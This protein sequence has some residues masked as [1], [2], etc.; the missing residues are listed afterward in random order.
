MASPSFDDLYIIAKAELQLRRPDLF[1]AAGDVSDFILA[2][3]AAAAD[4]CIQHTNEEMRKTFLD[5][6]T[7]D[8]LTVLVSDHFGITRQAATAAQVT[9]GFTRSVF[10]AGAGS[11]AIGTKVATEIDISGERQEFT[12]DAAV[13]WGATEVGTKTVLATAVV[14]GVAGNVAAA[15]ITDIVDAIFDANITLTNAAVAA[16][17]NEEESDAQLRERTRLYPSTIRRGTSDAVI[18]GALQVPSVRIA[19]VHEDSIGTAT[20]YVADEAGGSTAEMVADVEAELDEWR[21]AGVPITVTGGYLLEQDIDISLTIKAGTD[22]AALVADITAA[23]E[24]RIGRL[25][26]GD[27]EVTSLGV[28]RRELIQSAAMSVAPDRILGVTVNT[29]SADIVPDAGQIIRAGTITV[30]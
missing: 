28:L 24:N 29:P 14:E 18:Y 12:T 6:A 16:G 30:S 17:G 20:L 23:I 7:G 2:S 5:G 27:G 22:V 21:C 13:A 9:L 1:A 11:I 15:T 4:K 26:V 25:A 8:D 19:T 10:T 3:I